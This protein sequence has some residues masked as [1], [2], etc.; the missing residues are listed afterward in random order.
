MPR[1]ACPALDSV[2][3]RGRL[4]AALCRFLMRLTNETVTIELK[5]GTIV[6]GTVAGVDMSMNTHLKSVKMTLKNKVRARPVAAHGAHACRSCARRP[7]NR[8]AVRTEPRPPRQPFYSRQQRPLLHL[9]RELESRRAPC[10]HC[11]EAEARRG[12]CAHACAVQGGK[13]FAH[14]GLQVVAGRVD[15]AARAAEAVVARADAA[16]E[17]AAADVAARAAVAD[18][19]AS[20]CDRRPAHADCSCGHSATCL[21]LAEPPSSS[22]LRSFFLLITHSPLRQQTG[23]GWRLQAGCVFS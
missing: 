20:K 4:L 2:C 21:R 5:N 8:Y 16:E 6:H 23:C 19:I 14:A 17:T 7:T 1:G 22:R 15:A 13:R 10:G 11:Q 9:A 12:R 18:A 3:P